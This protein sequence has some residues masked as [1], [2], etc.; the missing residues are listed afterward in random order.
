MFVGKI[1]VYDGS[2]QNSNINY[3]IKEFYS[4]NDI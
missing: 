2:I 3:N 4:K 1:Y